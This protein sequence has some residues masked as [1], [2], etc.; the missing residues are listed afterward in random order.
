[1]SLLELEEGSETPELF[2]E[3]AFSNATAALY[4][5]GRDFML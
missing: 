4:M 5:M 1:M 3:G 2:A